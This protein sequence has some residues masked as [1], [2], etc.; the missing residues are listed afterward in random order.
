MRTIKGGQGHLSVRVSTRSLA[1]S[2]GM[3]SQENLHFRLPEIVSGAFSGTN[4]VL[5]VFQCS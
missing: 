2:G 5:H 1:G 4:L 3:L